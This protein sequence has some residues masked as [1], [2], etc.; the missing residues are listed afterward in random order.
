MICPDDGPEFNS[1]KEQVRAALELE[2]GKEPDLARRTG[3]WPCDGCA[4]PL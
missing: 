1:L 2:P 3:R 4:A